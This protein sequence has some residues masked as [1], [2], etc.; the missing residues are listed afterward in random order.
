VSGKKL[1]LLTFREHTSTHGSLVRSYNVSLRSALRVVMSVAIS[2]YT[3]ND[4]RIV[5]TSSRL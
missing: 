5:F 3:I 2:E 4:V 1:G